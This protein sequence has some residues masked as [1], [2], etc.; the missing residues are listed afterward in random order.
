MIRSVV[1]TSKADEDIDEFIFYL[2]EQSLEVAARFRDCVDKTFRHIAKMPE[3]KPIH[4][5]RH[6]LMKDVRI[7]AIDRFPNHLILYRIVKDRV[8]VVR[9]LHSSTNYMEIFES[10]NI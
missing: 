7:W 1:T 8:E 10:E 6:P 9:I 4:P 3:L 2:A 5:F